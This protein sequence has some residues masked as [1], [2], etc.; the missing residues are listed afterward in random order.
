MAESVK[1]RVRQITGQ[2]SRAAIADEG[3]GLRLQHYKRIQNTL[4]NLVARHQRDGH[5][6]KEFVRTLLD[7]EAV[8]IMTIEENCA[9]MRA[10]GDYHSAGIEL[11]AWERIGS[12]RRAELWKD[13]LHGKVADSTQF[14]EAATLEQAA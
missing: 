9:A 5:D 4:T 8:H 11:I 3:T 2:V 7:F 6:P 10:K 14:R 13:M 1:R 12:D